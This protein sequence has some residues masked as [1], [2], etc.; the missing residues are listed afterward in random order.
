MT[1]EEAAK[2]IVSKLGWVD[3]GCAEANDIKKAFIA[4]AEWQS[5]QPVIWYAA[6]PASNQ[7]AKLKEGFYFDANGNTFQLI[8]LSNHSQEVKSDNNG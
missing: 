1:R 3:D 6:V 7:N 2:E 8:D 5:Q 4:G